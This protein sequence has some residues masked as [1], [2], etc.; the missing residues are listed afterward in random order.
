MIQLD[1][2]SEHVRAFSSIY[3]R[4]A[5]NIPFLSLRSFCLGRGRKV[6]DVILLQSPPIMIHI[7][8]FVAKLGCGN[9]GLFI[10]VALK[11]QH[12]F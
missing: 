8:S 4:K 2:L 7:R 9:P 12:N 10:G 11:I 5:V 6:A 3:T 1:R